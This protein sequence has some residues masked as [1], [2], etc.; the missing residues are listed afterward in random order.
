MDSAWPDLLSCVSW[1]VGFSSHP[2]V[3]PTS[4]S[5]TPGTSR[6]ISSTPQKQPPASTA[7]S[8]FRSLATAERVL[9]SCSFISVLPSSYRAAA[10]V[11]PARRSTRVRPRDRGALFHRGTRRLF[12]Q[13]R[14]LRGL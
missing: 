8:V 2:P 5:I 12:D 13:P 6:R 11:A 7:T 10:R 9:P 3:Y 4:V 14:N 1:Y